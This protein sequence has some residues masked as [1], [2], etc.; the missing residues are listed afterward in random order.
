MGRVKIL[1]ALDTKSVLASEGGPG[2]DLRPCTGDGDNQAENTSP[3]C[4]ANF[5]TPPMFPKRKPGERG[6]TL[7]ANREGGNGPAP[8]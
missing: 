1:D 3:G 5:L 2:V 6:G 7:R 4:P 8:N